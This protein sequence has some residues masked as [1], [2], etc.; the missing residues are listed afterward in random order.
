MAAK[1]RKPSK[2][3]LA[4]AHALAL[5]PWYQ[6]KRFAFPVI[7]VVL[8]VMYA[9]VAISYQ[10]GVLSSLNRG[11]S[12]SEDVSSVDSSDLVADE[13]DASSVA[14]S[15]VDIGSET[16]NQKLARQNARNYHDSSW[17]SRVAMIDLIVAD[18]FSIAD[19]IH[20]VDSLRLDW[21]EEA[22]GMADMAIAADWFSRQGLVD[23]LVFQGFTENEASYAA[24]A[25][26][27]DWRKEAAGQALDYLEYAFYTYEELVDQL[28]YDGFTPE[29]AEYGA[30]ESKA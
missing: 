11:T 13:S 6:K 2:Q 3:E 22:V 24:D 26:G 25:I 1:K 18:G 21:S 30:S 20:G 4:L 7:G 10:A 17:L 14:V 5:R 28:V 9:S 15:K 29:E 27:V 19:A 12:L 23:H 8:A 16:E